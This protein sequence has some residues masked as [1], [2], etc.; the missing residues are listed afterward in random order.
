M[1]NFEKHKD[2]ILEHVNKGEAFALHKGKLKECNDVSCLECEFGVDQFCADSW[3]KV[4]QWM[5][6]EYEEPKTLTRRQRAFCEAVETGWLARNANG[7]LEIHLKKPKKGSQYWSSG[8]SPTY[9]NKHF[10]DFP[11]IKWE[12]EPYS[13]EEMLTWEVEGE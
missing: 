12:D 2:F 3:V 7:S 1:T 9:V 8:C 13:I 11:F 5:F 4:L 6:S 10:P